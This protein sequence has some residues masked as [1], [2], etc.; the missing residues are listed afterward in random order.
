[1]G[2]W[3]NLENNLKWAVIVTVTGLIGVKNYSVGKIKMSMSIFQWNVTV[4]SDKP[5]VKILFLQ[6][7]HCLSAIALFQLWGTLCKVK[8]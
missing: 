6:I 8:S 4:S 3:P 2:K 1:M 5:R 7:M